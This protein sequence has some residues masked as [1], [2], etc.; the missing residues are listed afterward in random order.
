[1]N[2]F[3]HYIGFSSTVRSSVFSGSSI[4]DSGV[5]IVRNSSLLSTIAKVNIEKSVEEAS[6]DFLKY[7]NMPMC[8][9]S[10]P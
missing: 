8:A 5:D 4:A 3:L 1:M 6:Q 2:L 9:L 7:H 10:Q